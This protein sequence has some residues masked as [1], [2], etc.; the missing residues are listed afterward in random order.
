MIKD[1]GDAY[2]AS[3]GKGF[4]SRAEATDINPEVLKDLI[5]SFELYDDKTEIID[6]DD[7][8]ALTTSDMN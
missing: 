1:D 3:L 5:P 8:P 7:K 6:I 2:I 4:F